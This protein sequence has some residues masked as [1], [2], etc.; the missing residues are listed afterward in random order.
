A[1]APGI[2]NNSIYIAEPYNS[3]EVNT[4]DRAI[5]AAGAASSYDFRN[6]FNAVANYANKHGGFAGRALKPIYFAYNATDDSNTQDQSA[7]AYWTQDHKVFVLDGVFG[8]IL[9]S[10]AEKEGAVAFGAGST[11]A[12]YKQ[13]PHMI[14][15]I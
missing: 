14:S 1:K 9:Q 7:C 10:C 15:P 12:E 2:T 4:A 5:G 3:A 13:Y 8:Q 11:A 6:V